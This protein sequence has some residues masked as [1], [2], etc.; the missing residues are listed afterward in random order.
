MGCVASYFWF[1]SRPY[2]FIKLGHNFFKCI[3][4][5]RSDFIPFGYSLRPNKPVSSCKYELYN[6]I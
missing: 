2:L 5:K 3:Y 1:K 4:L 6:D